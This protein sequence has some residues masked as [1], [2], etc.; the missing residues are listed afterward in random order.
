MRTAFCGGGGLLSAG[1][2]SAAGV[3][4]IIYELGVDVGSTDVE[5]SCVTVYC[6]YILVEGG[7]AYVEGG[8]VDASNSR[9]FV[10]DGM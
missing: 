10:S 7:C 5:G 1:G 2:L 6:S 4:I 3:D 8:F 9:A